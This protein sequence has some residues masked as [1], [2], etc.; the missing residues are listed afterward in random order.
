MP[1]SLG[2]LSPID[3]TIHSLNSLRSPLI[4]ESPLFPDFHGSPSFEYPLRYTSPYGIHIGETPP[5]IVEPSVSPL[6]LIVTPGGMEPDFEHNVVLNAPVMAVLVPTPVTFAW[7]R[8][9]SPE[10]QRQVI[11]SSTQS[12]CIVNLKTQPVT[13]SMLATRD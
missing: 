11:V 2:S 13:F 1:S 9:Q 12:P 3:R 5:E 4:V 10:Q 8:A 6:R 7:M